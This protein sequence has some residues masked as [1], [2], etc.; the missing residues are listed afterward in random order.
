MTQNEESAYLVSHTVTIRVYWKVSTVVDW[1][2]KVL[3][4]VLLLLYFIVD[5]ISTVSF[6]VCP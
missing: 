2:T 6:I 3:T 5:M 4:K 1:P